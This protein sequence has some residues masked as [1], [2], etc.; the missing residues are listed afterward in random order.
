MLR[1]D[2]Y[3]DFSS[4]HSYLQLER[5]AGLQDRLSVVCRPLEASRLHDGRGRAGSRSVERERAPAP[6]HTTWAARKLRIPP[7][8][9][10]V[11]PFCSRR[12]LVLSAALNSDFAVVLTIFRSI[13]SHPGDPTRDEFFERVVADL[14]VVFDGVEEL[15][16]DTAMQILN[17]NAQSAAA[18]NVSETPSLVVDNLVFSG[19]DATNA[20]IEHV[21]RDALDGRG[22]TVA[23]LRP[24]RNTVESTH[25]EPE[26]SERLISSFAPLSIDTLTK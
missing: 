12:Y 25:N 23:M 26:L 18:A 20:F 1:I 2:W 8:I 21:G 15:V 6:L 10:N 11:Q 9:S 4:Y 3:F 14:G 22:A 7:R 19:L 5:L 24:L 16:H 13:Y 17:T